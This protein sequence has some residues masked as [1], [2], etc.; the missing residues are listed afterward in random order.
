MSDRQSEKPAVNA[1][2]FN[3][4][5]PTR[6]GHMIRDRRLTKGR[7]STHGNMSAT[8]P[9]RAS[10]AQSLSMLSKQTDSTRWC[11]RLHGPAWLAS[12]SRKTAALSGPSLHFCSTSD[13]VLPSAIYIHTYICIYKHII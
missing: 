6:K 9:H 3:L 5:S 13:A 7:R 8:K 10:E 4:S 2:R 11:C 1:A 12:S